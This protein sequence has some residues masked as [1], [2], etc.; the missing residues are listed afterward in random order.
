L[1]ELAGFSSGHRVDI[2]RL[3]QFQ[4]DPR[5]YRELWRRK[6][7]PERRDA[8]FSLLVD[9]SVSMDGSKAEAA[10]AGTVLLCETLAR[11][12]VRFAV[13]GFQDRLIPFVDF[14]DD[15]SHAVR[16]HLP[17]MVLETTGNRPG[18]HNQ[19]G[20]NDDGPCLLAAAAALTSHASRVLVVISDGEPNGTNS[21]PEDLRRAVA[22]LARAGEIEL[23]AIGLGPETAH[24]RSY[25]PRSV[26]NVPASELAGRVGRVIEEALVG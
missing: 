7:L 1:R 2:R 20:N 9:L 3:M 15:W 22:D 8:C 16:G 11:L 25:Y 10:L 19:P 14:G 4:A 13:N 21:G 23:V 5:R 18:G 26:A 6:S 17:G 24:V 12:G